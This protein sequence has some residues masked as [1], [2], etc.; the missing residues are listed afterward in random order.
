[1]IRGLKRVDA[2][3]YHY[4][5]GNRVGGM[6]NKLRGDCSGL[7]GDCTDLCGN[8]TD[9]RGDLDECKISDE[10]RKGGI[11]ITVLVSS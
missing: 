9:L 8:C 11:D 6:H 7:R 1:M 5:G 2:G 10:E 3:L 4:V